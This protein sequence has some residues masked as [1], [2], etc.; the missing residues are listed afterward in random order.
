[1]INK[2]TIID[3][4]PGIDDALALTTALF[5]EKL[6][7]QLITTVP[8]NVNVELTTK[9]AL[10]LVEYLGVDVP[11]AKGADAPLLVELEDASKYHGETGLDGFDFQSLKQE[12]LAKNGIQAMAETILANEEKTLIFALGPLTNIALLINAFPEVKEKIEQII[13][14]GGS[15]THGNTTSAAEFNI[16]SDPHAAEMVFQSGLKLSMFGLNVTYEAVLQKNNIEKI[17]DMGDLGDMLYSILE[18]YRGGSFET[19]LRLH[20]TCTIAYFDDPSLFE[21]KDMLI[22][23]QTEGISRGATVVD[24]ENKASEGNVTVAVGVDNDRFQEWL[25]NGLKHAADKLS[26]TL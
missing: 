6:D 2:P 18:H 21:T 1:M 13:I 12:P 10:Q 17:K 11:V 4:D 23:V 15:L 19:G 16:Y 7:V 5:N 14:M 24:I 8:G 3:T 22:N 20:D 25:V 26:K 9:N